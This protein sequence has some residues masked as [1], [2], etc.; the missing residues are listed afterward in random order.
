M[1]ERRARHVPVLDGDAVVGVVSIGDVLKA[2]LAEKVEENA[3]LQELARLRFA[4]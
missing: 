4:A 2:R 1:T 3:V